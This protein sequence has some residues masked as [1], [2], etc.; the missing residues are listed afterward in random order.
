MIVQNE[1]LGWEIQWPQSM[2]DKLTQLAVTNE[3]KFLDLREFVHE[4]YPIIDTFH[5]DCVTFEHGF[6]SKEEAKAFESELKNTVNTWI[7]RCC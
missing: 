7:R 6:N 1:Y 5:T 2:E 4:T 3:D